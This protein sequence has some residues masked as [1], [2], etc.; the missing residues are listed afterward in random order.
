MGYG[1]ILGGGEESD[2]SYSITT[3]S[4]FANLPA[5]PLQNTIG[6]ITTVAVGEVYITNKTLIGLENGDVVIRMGNPALNRFDAVEV[7]TIELCP[8]DAYQQQSGVLTRVPAFIYNGTAWSMIVGKFLEDGILASDT[9]NRANG[10]P[11][12]ADVGGNWTIVNATVAIAS[13]KLKGTQATFNNA[14]TIPLNQ[15][16]VGIFVDFT[17]YTGET[18]GIIARAASGYTTFMRLRYDGTNFEITKAISGETVVATFGYA[19]TSGTTHRI[20]FACAGNAFAGYINGAVVITA[21]DD[22]ETKTGARVGLSFAKNGTVPSATADN[23]I[24]VG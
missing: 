15:V 19:W 5:T 22:N 14:A 12:T 1:I 6:L 17:W 16:D 8:V 21:I 2:F 13:Q 23:L 24:V 4:A 18:I 10:A 7:G 11:G 20:G 3:A 9:F